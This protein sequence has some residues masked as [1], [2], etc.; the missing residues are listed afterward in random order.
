MEIGV[1][2]TIS[3]LAAGS[4]LWLLLL[5]VTF[6]SALVAALLLLPVA[7]AAVAALLAFAFAFLPEGV[8]ALALAFALA[9]E[10]V[11]GLICGIWVHGLVRDL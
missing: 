7:L 9:V 5:P 3:T 6:A 2:G 11:Q 4:L 1:S 10:R 8:L